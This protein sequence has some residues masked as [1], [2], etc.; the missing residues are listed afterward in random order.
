VLDALRSFF[1][2]GNEGY[3]LTIVAPTRNAA[4]LLNGSTYHYTFRI[5]DYCELS[6]ASLAS[7][8]DHLLGVD[9]IFLDEMSMLSCHDSFYIHK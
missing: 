6:N 3:W 2:F 8:K 4:S 7:I 9:Y 1:D 5:N